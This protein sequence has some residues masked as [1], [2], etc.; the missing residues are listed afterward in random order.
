MWCRRRPARNGRGVVGAARGG[1]FGSSSASR[2][3]RVGNCAREQGPRGEGGEGVQN[4]N[5]G[6]PSNCA[7]CAAT[8]GGNKSAVSVSGGGGGARL[9]KRTFPQRPKST[10]LRPWRLPNASGGG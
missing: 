10:I 5:G 3:A 8:H 2:L 1:V 9:P 4:G 7:K 6:A